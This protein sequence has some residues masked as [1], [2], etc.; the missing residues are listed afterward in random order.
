MTSRTACADAPAPT[1]ARAWWPPAVAMAA[2][3]WGA[4]Q[5]APLIVLYERHGVS[6]SAATVMFGL[7]A[8]GLVPALV[9]GGRW[10]DRAGRRTVVHRALLLSLVATGT[11][12]AGAGM[13][14][15]LFPGRFLAGVSSGLAFGT[16]AAWI[17]EL[18][19]AEGKPGAGPRRSAVAMTA[20][21][22]G[23]PLVAG[24]IAQWAPRPELAAYLP[25]LLLCLL[26]LRLMVRVPDTAPPA[27][28]AGR[29]PRFGGL[30]PRY[31]L[32]VVL[33]LGPWVFGTAAVALAYLPGLA[34]G[35]AGRFHLAF[36][37]LA[38]AVPAFAGVLVQPVAAR[39][40]GT[41]GR[42]VRVAIATVPAGF[43]VAAWA[44]TA[45]SA[46]IALLAEVVLGAAYGLTLL[47]GL[48][49]VQRVADPAGLGA[50]TATY[51][52]ICYL[53]F[54]LP[55]L[56]TAAHQSWGWSPTLGLLVLL[57]LSLAAAG[58]LFAV[59][60]VRSRSATR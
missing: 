48:S 43:A 6:A 22:G 50:A 14:W 3:G 45:G 17:R 59:T 49:A 20:G 16:G 35:S 26:A 52:A 7:Y 44:A 4:N 37:A 34:A 40:H 23:G 55:Y 5:F 24:L 10:S 42:L 58:W 8:V 46:G 33:P 32:F 41:E 9:A 18:A 30:P 2:I 54:A 27:R 11:L 39:L 36:A 15:W 56:L 29:A 25:H 47:A 1:A 12:L 57:A 51:Q 53:G 19:V 38:T 60:A 21:F 28:P 31:L 13:H